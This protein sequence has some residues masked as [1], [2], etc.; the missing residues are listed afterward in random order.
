MIRCATL[1]AL[2]LLTGL[3]AVAGVAGAFGSLA[4]L[5]VSIAGFCLMISLC[6]ELFRS[7]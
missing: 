4:M 1:F 5:A 2:T 6:N 3:V 7:N